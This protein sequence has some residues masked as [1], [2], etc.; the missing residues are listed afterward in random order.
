MTLRAGV[1]SSADSIDS[2]TFTQFRRHAWKQRGERMEMGH[3]REYNQVNP[4]ARC[5]SG[6]LFNVF[7]IAEVLCESSPSSVQSS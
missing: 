7:S 1:F 5:D 6:W 3:S 4:A 2:E